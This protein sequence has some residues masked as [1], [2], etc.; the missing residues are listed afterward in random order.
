MAISSR[1]NSTSR[2]NITFFANIADYLADDAGLI[3]IR[4]KDVAEPPLEP[5]SDGSKQAVKYTNMI[6]PPLLVLGYGLMRWRK[7]QFMKKLQ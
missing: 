2:D 5:V 6:L 3:D 7:R 4:S 1:S